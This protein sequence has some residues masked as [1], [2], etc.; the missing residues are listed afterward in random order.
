MRVI[1]TELALT[2][3]DSP[4]N[5]SRIEDSVA[6]SGL[7]PGADD[8]LVLPELVDFR[9]EARVYEER[10]AGLAGSLG[11]HVIGGSQRRRDPDG[12]RNAGIVSGPDGVV[13]AR[14]QK[15]RPYGGDLDARPGDAHAPLSIGG[16]SVR[17]LICADFW[18]SD[19]WRAQQPVDL[20]L[21][22][23]LSVS[24]K[25]TPD[26]SR[27][28]WK[29]AAIARAFEFG[30]FVGISDWSFGT[31]SSGQ[32]A[33]GVAGLAD[34][35]ATNPDELFRAVSPDSIRAFELDYEALERLHADRDAMAFLSRAR[36]KDST[37]SARRSK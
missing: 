37:A 27:T 9:S 8:I 2:T 23:S 31:L 34:P 5:F 32:T 12:L 4:G 29:S 14:Y 25:P 26:Y 20:V 35:T 18:Y 6:A 33:S 1:L 21:V 13:L 22:V 10:V 16:R 19:L 11:C 30:A 3:E 28:L 17:I 36:P 7:A 15:M 24:R